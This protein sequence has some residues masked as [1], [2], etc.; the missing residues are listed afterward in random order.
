MVE[1]L[2]NIEDL[3]V[4]YWITTRGPRENVLDELVIAGPSAVE[5]KLD[6]ASQR[7]YNGRTKGMKEEYGGD[8]HSNQG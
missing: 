7:P 5:V 1:P 2:F 6:R 4:R 8:F 3:M